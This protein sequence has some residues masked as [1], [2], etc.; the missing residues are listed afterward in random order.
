MRGRWN[1][2]VGV[3]LAVALA[4]V[5]S[6]CGGSSNTSATS[7]TG[8][9]SVVPA[10]APVY[11]SI[12]TDIT[13]AQWQTA[14][15]LLDNFPDK[16]TFL[17]KLQ[18]SFKSNSGLDWQTD[19]KPALGPEIDVA[20]LDFGQG[21]NIVALL[22]PADDAK[23]AAMVKKGNA[24]DPTSPL[25]Y[26]KVGDW[27]VVSDTQVKIDLFK[28]QSKGAKLA[29][30]STFTDSMAQLSSEALASFLA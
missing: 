18:A 29:D 11:L 28:Q 22:Q 9:A 27:T 24:K 5:A 8:A 13:S 12:D 1:W 16:A 20:V 25:V 26:E 15:K 7:G 3:A 4:V 10:S 23:F 6:A 30:D 14:D 17:S 2:F 21:T 19:I